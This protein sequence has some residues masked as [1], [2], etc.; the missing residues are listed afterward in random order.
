M[1]YKNNIK[2]EENR[3]EDMEYGGK[4]EIRSL[5]GS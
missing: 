4:V 5:K 2:I 3:G 1:E